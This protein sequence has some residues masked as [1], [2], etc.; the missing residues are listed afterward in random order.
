M[1]IG[2]IIVNARSMIQDRI[3]LSFQDNSCLNSNIH[4]DEQVGV[5]PLHCPFSW[6]VLVLSPT[7]WY[8]ILQVYVAIDAGVNPD[9]TTRPFDG[10][11]K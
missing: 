5:V 10:S 11:F 6:Q 4:G 8:P 3:L 7:S 2:Y 1:Q 9:T